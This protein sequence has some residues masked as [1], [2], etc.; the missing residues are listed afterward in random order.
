MIFETKNFQKKIKSKI[1]SY[2]H[3]YTYFIILKIQKKIFN[4]NYIIL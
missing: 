1:K 3:I 2:S 4:F